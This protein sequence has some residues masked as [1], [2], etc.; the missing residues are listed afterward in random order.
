MKKTR[1]HNRISRGFLILAAAGAAA[2]VFP[3]GPSLAIVAPPTPQPGPAGRNESTATATPVPAAD[4]L[5]PLNSS[6]LVV[7]DDRVGSGFTAD[8]TQARAHLKEALAQS[9]TVLAPAGTPVYIKV[10]DVRAAHAPDVDGS[11]N[12]YFEPLALSNGSS[13]ALRAPVSHLSVETTAGAASTSQVTDTIKDIF[14][15]YHYLYRMFRKGANVDLHP[16]TIL[17]AR[18]DAIVVKSGAGF[19]VV[20]AA[21]RALSIDPPHV[22][23]KPYPFYTVPPKT[24]APKPSPT[25]TPLP[26]PSVSPTP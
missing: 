8:G 24:P 4:Q 25:V 17:R 7:L 3:A 5:L 21:P 22:D 13:L 9:G 26:Q 15:P 16:G 14:I 18:T 11:L 20:N 1:L 2:I 6:I 10:T 12:I 23:Y 19:A